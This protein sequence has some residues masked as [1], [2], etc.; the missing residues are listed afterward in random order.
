MGGPRVRRS[1]EEW[2]EIIE[3][4]QRSGLSRARF[5]RRERIARTTFEKWEQKLRPTG[6]AGFVELTSTASGSESWSLELELPGGAI[7]RFRG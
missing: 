4:Q 7:L 1:P 2:R 5:C 6:D 3:Q